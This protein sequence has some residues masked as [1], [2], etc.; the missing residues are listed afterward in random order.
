MKQ[1]V[2]FLL[3]ILGLGLMT[4][5]EKDDDNNSNTA[6]DQYVDPVGT[7]DRGGVL[8]AVRTFSNSPVTVPGVPSIEI[9]VDVPVAVF[10]QGGNAVDAGT[11]SID[12]EQLV[13]RSGTYTMDQS[14]L[15]NGEIFNFENRSWTVAGAGSTP[16][17]E[18]THSRPLPTLGELNIPESVNKG[19]P[20]TM[21]VSS[22]SNADSLLFNLGGVVKRVGAQTR[23]V[24][25][26]AEETNSIA[27]GNQ[28]V[29]QAAAYS[30]EQRSSGDFPIYLI[31]QSVRS[32]FIPAN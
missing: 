20:F 28:T 16:A 4:A 23:S 26:S 2:P 7:L 12:G 22:V 31:N 9:E 19:E 24:T 8:I 25:F 15:I 32:E 30:I 3:L 10:Y 27:S 6:E 13:L 1:L 11:V 14:S 17:F 5:C 29:A 18:A 21:S